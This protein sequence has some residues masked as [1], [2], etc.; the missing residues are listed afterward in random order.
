[1]FQDLKVVLKIGSV[2]ESRSKMVGVCQ[3]KYMVLVLFLFIAMSFVKSLEKE[4]HKAG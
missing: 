1:M 4:G 2:K 3:G